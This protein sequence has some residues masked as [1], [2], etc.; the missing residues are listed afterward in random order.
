MMDDLDRYIAGRSE[1]ESEFA[2]GLV[3]AEAELALGLQLAR[4]REKRGWTQRQL[5]ER[6]GMPQPAIARLEKAGRTPT[7]TTL[8]RL[9][10]ALDCTILLGPDFSVRLID[11]AREEGPTDEIRTTERLG[12]AV[13]S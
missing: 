1:R 12:S 7:V 4:L 8:W 6:A 13:P 9:A 2:Q 3:E 5:A 11:L 10:R